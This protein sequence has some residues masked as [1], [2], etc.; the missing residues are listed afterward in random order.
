MSP[1]LRL[2]LLKWSVVG[3]L[4]AMVLGG[5]ALIH[6]GPVHGYVISCDKTQQITCGLQRDTSQELQYWQVPLGASATATV[7]V[8]T[9]RRSRPRVFLYLNSDAQSVFAAEFEDGDAAAHA[10]ATA[11]RLNQLFSSATPASL[12]IEVRPPSHMKPL[13]WGG[14]GFFVLLV[15]VIYRELFKPEPRPDKSSKPTPLRDP[16]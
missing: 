10:H 5:A 9:N 15:L 6:F 8:K 16:A 14:F 13:I 3:L 1:S 2:Q 4:A 12:R 11:A 7:Q